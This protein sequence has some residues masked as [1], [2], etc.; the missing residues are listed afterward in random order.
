MVLSLY[1]YSLGAK[2][3]MTSAT[4]EAT[5]K[6]AII[7][8]SYS[9]CREKNNKNHSTSTRN[10]R[11]QCRTKLHKEYIRWI[12][13]KEKKNSAYYARLASVNRGLYIFYFPLSF[14]SFFFSFF[15]LLFFFSSRTARACGDRVSGLNSKREAIYRF[16][17][18]C[19]SLRS[20]DA[21]NEAQPKHSTRDKEL[22]Q[23]P[24]QNI[25]A[26]SLFFSPFF[27]SLS[28]S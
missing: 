18:G 3:N 13:K 9:S 1:K 7:V 28:F 23:S 21:G 26:L 4:R 19:A 17:P 25:D 15:F 8:H 27:P 10:Y 11:V 16:R 24:F 12:W 5:S 14:K 2:V 6:I 22:I 20:R